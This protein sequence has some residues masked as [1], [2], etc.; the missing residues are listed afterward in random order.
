MG[1][2]A[3]SRKDPHKGGSGARPWMAVSHAEHTRGSTRESRTTPETIFARPASSVDAGH[4]GAVSR[5]DGERNGGRARQRRWVQRRRRDGGQP[6]WVPPH[7]PRLVVPELGAGGHDTRPVRVERSGV[8]LGQWRE[9]PRRLGDQFGRG[10]I[11]GSQGE[12]RGE[13]VLLLYGF[14][15]RPQL[16]RVVLL[17]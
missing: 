8:W 12:D 17:S 6:E 7:D 14:L 16:P 1:T 15:V 3:R 4:G 10:R 2:R 5:A 13:L 9:Q 11:V